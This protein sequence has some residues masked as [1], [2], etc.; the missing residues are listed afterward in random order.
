MLY[1]KCDRLSVKKNK[2]K[3]IN[4]YKLLEILNTGLWKR[5]VLDFSLWK[6]QQPRVMFPLI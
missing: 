1:F 3:Y 5:N 2:K 4:I 6:T